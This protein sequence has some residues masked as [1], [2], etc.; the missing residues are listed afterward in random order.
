MEDNRT[1]ER[2][3]TNAF[4]RYEDSVN[5]AVEFGNKIGAPDKGDGSLSSDVSHHLDDHDDQVAGP[6]PAPSKAEIEDSD[7][8]LEVNAD[9]EGVKGVPI[10]PDHFSPQ[11][12]KPGP[13]G[14]SNP[15][16]SLD[17]PTGQ[18]GAAPN[19]DDSYDSEPDFSDENA[20]EESQHSFRREQFGDAH[21]HRAPEKTNKYS[22]AGE[23]HE[24]PMDSYSEGGHYDED[25]ERD[26]HNADRGGSRHMEIERATERVEINIDSGSEKEEEDHLLQKEERAAAAEDNASL[27]RRP[28]SS[29]SV[30]KKAPGL[31]RS[32]PT[33]TS[34]TPSKQTPGQEAA[35]SV[36]TY[37]TEV[38]KTTA[39]R[40]KTGRQYSK[41]NA[42]ADLTDQLDRVF[43]PLEESWN[44]LDEGMKMYRIAV[45][46]ILI[47]FAEWVA[48]VVV[49]ALYLDTHSY[50]EYARDEDG[51]LLEHHV[52]NF[53]PGGLVILAAIL[54]PS[55]WH[56]I[57]QNG[58]FYPST[59][60]GLS[61]VEEK[62]HFI[63]AL[64]AGMNKTDDE[65]TEPQ[66]LHEFCLNDFCCFDS[67]CG[68][69]GCCGKD[70]SNAEQ[71]EDPAAKAESAKLVP[72]SN[73]GAGSGSQPEDEEEDTNK[74]G[75]AS[76]DV[77]E[78]E[79]RR[80]LLN[81]VAA[82]ENAAARAGGG[83]KQAEE[84]NQKV[85]WFNRINKFQECDMLFHSY[86]SLFI[87]VYILA[88]RREC[89]S[90]FGLPI[91][92][93]CTIFT[94]AVLLRA[95]R[96]KSPVFV[97]RHANRWS[98]RFVFSVFVYLDFMWRS[99]AYALFVR[100]WGFGYDFIFGTFIILVLL[101][102]MG[103]PRP[104]DKLKSCNEITVMF[105][106]LFTPFTGSFHLL[107]S[108]SSEQWPRV[109][110]VYWLRYVINIVMCSWGIYRSDW[111]W[112]YD[113]GESSR[114]VVDGYEG[115]HHGWWIALV[116]MGSVMYPPMLFQ[117][118]YWVKTG[119]YDGTV[120]KIEEGKEIEVPEAEPLTAN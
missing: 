112:S 19:D 103:A 92:L 23:N 13:E 36:K 45:W 77:E 115:H 91:F 79:E 2:N 61:V 1:G 117:L 4:P 46:G 116:V 56:D 76:P 75:D 85:E 101:E 98:R 63:L 81:E 120:C 41:H 28:L 96:L 97:G 24:S 8:E 104:T 12:Q 9:R 110:V 50:Y 106:S 42:W 51:K 47:F 11:S 74:N 26:H 87:Q 59:I 38:Y 99:S 48:N 64:H 94:Y 29:P 21:D 107:G 25:I 95:L 15:E 57:I 66:P 90:W 10:R 52:P 93:S 109:L 108:D 102:Y 113:D 67:C 40:A 37:L 35:Q 72:A 65:T 32:P 88:Y 7:V 18:P 31:S 68:N 78:Q 80:E 71:N 5:S 55:F 118:S 70:K 20:E 17:A 22:K 3:L 53:I 100:A 119:A 33:D 30:V 73:N 34:I 84:M 114:I 49:L 39:H 86:P 6:P 60:F 82:Q 16:S 89:S 54:A 44:S 58:K 69:E 83:V 111:F 27:K 43:S 105:Y 62:I 14:A